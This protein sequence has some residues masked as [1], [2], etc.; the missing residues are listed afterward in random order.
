MNDKYGECYCGDCISFNKCK[1][2][3]GTRIN[4]ASEG[5]SCFEPNDVAKVD[6][7]ILPKWLAEHDE[8]M[9]KAA[10]LDKVAEKLKAKYPPYFNEF[11]MS[12]NN[13]L[14]EDIDEVI[15]EIKAEIEVSE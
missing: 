15:A 12:V 6:Y 7:P 4:L 11:G 3:K 2:D 1:S 8:Q 9:I 13:T 14:H 5:C 10:L